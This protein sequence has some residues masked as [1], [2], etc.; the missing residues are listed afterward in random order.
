MD[1]TIYFK[2]GLQLQIDTSMG[3]ELSRRLCKY[4]R[5]PQSENRASSI[6]YSDGGDTNR[7][8]LVDLDSIFAMQHGS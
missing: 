7:T 8:L 4:M 5:A 1:T 3:E 2:N 6:T